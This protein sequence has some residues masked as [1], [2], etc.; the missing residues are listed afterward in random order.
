[1]CQAARRT[2]N[3]RECCRKE[4][5]GWLKPSQNFFQLLIAFSSFVWI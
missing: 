2:E 3:A 1:M 4:H 5:M